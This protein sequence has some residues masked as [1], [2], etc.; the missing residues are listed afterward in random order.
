MIFTW[1]NR[2]H[3]ECAVCEPK[4]VI[5]LMCIFTWIRANLVR[6]TIRRECVE[7][8]LF[9]CILCGCLFFLGL[10]CVVNFCMR[11]L[12]ASELSHSISAYQ[13][14]WAVEMT[15][16]AEGMMGSE[17]FAH[18][19]RRCWVIFLMSF[20]CCW[21]FNIRTRLCIPWIFNIVP[22]H[23]FDRFIYLSYGEN[24]CCCRATKQTE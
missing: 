6:T 23:K 7:W 21:L 22:F 3:V 19:R 15:F 1:I 18:I 13:Q 11:S 14:H 10:N 16:I 12:C 9:R 5:H 17:K 2:H 4:R 8:L 20:C 24:V